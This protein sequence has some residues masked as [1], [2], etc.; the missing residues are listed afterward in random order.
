MILIPIHYANHWFLVQYNEKEIVS[1]DPYDYPE[2]N[3]LKK[4]QLLEENRKFH[5]RI[6]MDL[7]DHYFKPLYTKYRKKWMDLLIQYRVVP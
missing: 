5:K 2:S 4:Q 7:R 1:Y 6:L 3:G